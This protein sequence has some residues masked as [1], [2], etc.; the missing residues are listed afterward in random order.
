M[1]SLTKVKYLGSKIVKGKLVFGKKITP[2]KGKI[3]IIL[4]KFNFITFKIIIE[5][6]T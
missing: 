3:G 4:G 5:K 6:S 1:Q 2:L